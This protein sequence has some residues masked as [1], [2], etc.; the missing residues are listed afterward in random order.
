LNSTKKALIAAAV[1]VIFSLGLIFWQVKARKGP[2]VLSP[3]DMTLIAE[4][5]PTKLRARILP[6]TFG[7]CW[8]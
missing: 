1:A 2:V 5:R 7:G 6:W 3:E 4:D 8:L